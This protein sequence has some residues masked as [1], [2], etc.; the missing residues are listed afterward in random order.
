MSP[1]STAPSP[2]GPTDFTLSFHAP[3]GSTYERSKVL[4]ARAKLNG[5][6]ELLTAAWEQVLGFGRH[7]L[8]GKALSELMLPSEAAGA[9]A[10]I[11][12]EPDSGPVE[13]TLRCRNGEAK[14]FRLH[15]RC[16]A[17]WGRMFIVADEIP[18]ARERTAFAS[19]RE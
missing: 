7:E 13:L 10:A 14:S 8:D 19:A 17:Y 4:L 16:D 2:A 15:R 18:R 12:D 6:L 1:A 3:P 11:L 9:V 5:T